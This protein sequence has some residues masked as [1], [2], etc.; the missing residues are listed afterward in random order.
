VEAV[1]SLPTLARVAE[2][3][4][5]EAAAANGITVRALSNTAEFRR[6][7]ALLQQIW[8][9]PSEPLTAETLVALDFSGNYVGA[10]LVG[11]EIVGVS[12][13][14]RN[15]R[16]SLHSHIA[17]IAPEQQGRSVGYILKLHQRAWALNHD[18]S[19]IGWTFD[20]LVRRNA[21]FNLVKLGAAAAEYLQDFYG[22]M[23]DTFNSGGISDRL[24][25]EWDLTGPVPGR[26]VDVPETAHNVLSVGNDGM[27]VEA[28]SD[29]AVVTVSL[30]ADLET[31]R[32]NGQEAGAEWR[33]ALR[34]AL[35]GAGAR[36][37]RIAGMDVT[38]SYV[39]V[40]DEPSAD[41]SE[42]RS[43]GTDG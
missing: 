25:V 17:G 4:V 37:Y 28:E 7:A 40:R 16:G 24:Y 8:Q 29:S 5:D 31:L 20:P 41:A 11:D 9:S 38:Q 12:V 43:E 13:G 35:H 36:G 26:Y 42:A 2:S 3:A 39:L 33:L 19:E 30:P 1:G 18:I 6:A 10:A 22:P 14:F 34:R 32:A 23:E 27:P 21:H 15:D